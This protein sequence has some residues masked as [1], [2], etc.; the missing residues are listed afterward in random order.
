MEHTMKMINASEPGRW[1]CNAMK[2]RKSL[3]ERK[4]RNGRSASH[5][6]SPE[7]RDG[8]MLYLFDEIEL[9]E[10]RFA[11]EVIVDQVLEISPPA[12]IQHQERYYR[13]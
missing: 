12:N 6:I 4:G 7:S 1:F 9:V 11:I 5:C 8:E 13:E 2:F 3:T 10:C